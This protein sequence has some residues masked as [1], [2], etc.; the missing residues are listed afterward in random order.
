MFGGS[1]TAVTGIVLQQIYDNF[2]LNGMQIYFIAAIIGLITYVLVSLL[3]KKAVFNMDRLLHRGK[4]ATDDTQ[5]I[6][7]SPTSRL[8][9]KL[10][11]TD[12]FSRGDRVIYIGTLL[13]NV[14]WFLFFLV[15]VIYNVIVDVP[16]ESWLGFW[17]FYI[18]FLF[19]ISAGVLVWLG[20][21]GIIDV[22]RMFKRL[23]SMHR[24]Q[25]DDGW[26]VDHVSAGEE[27]VASEEKE[28]N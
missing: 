20:V 23:A 7:G 4:Y 6:V 11:M 8:L 21:G 5:R 24:I 1:G 27:L 16:Q 28:S 9:K 3:G 10:G 26:V 15:V 17:H 25:E 18:W 19:S 2:P 13:W 12:E 22:R 14:L